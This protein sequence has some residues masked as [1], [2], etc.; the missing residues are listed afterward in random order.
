[1]M[2]SITCGSALTVITS[3]TPLPK[4]NTPAWLANLAFHTFFTIPIL[5]FNGLLINIL[6]RGIM[7]E[8]GIL[9]NCM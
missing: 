7:T 2:V 1:M 4:V 8:K 9:L 3:G 5:L 6:V